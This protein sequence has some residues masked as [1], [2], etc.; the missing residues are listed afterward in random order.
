MALAVRSSTGASPRST[1][2]TLPLSL[3]TEFT[4]VTDVWKL[5]LVT[6]GGT[7]KTEVQVDAARLSWQDD[8]R[9]AHD[10]GANRASSARNEV[11]G[12]RLSCRRTTLGCVDKP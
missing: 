10:L 5:L 6:G 11:E 12:R 1:A 7:L 2:P 8:R 4:T 3:R 9:P